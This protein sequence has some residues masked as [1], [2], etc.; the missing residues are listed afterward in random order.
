[1]VRA[2]VMTGVGRPLEVCEVELELPRAHE[3]MVRMAASGVCHSD[4]SMQDGT[5]MAP[6]PIVLGHEGAGVVEQVGPGVDAVE[7]GDHVVIAWV[8]QCGS[9]FFCRRGQRHLCELANVVLAS[10]GLLD[11]SPR[12]SSGGRPLY[13]MVAAGTFAELTVVPESGVVKVDDALDL[14]VAALLG[15]AVLTGVGA[16]TRTADISEGDSVAVVGCGGVGLNVVQGARLAGA[17]QVIAVDVSPAKLDLA[18]QFGATAAVDAGDG[19]PVSRVMELTAQRGTDVSFEVV[20][21]QR[22]IDQTIAM[23]RRGGQAVLVGIPKMDVMLQVPAFLGA[24]MAAKT[25]TGC[26]YGSA[27][28]RRDVPRIVEHYG[29]GDLKLDE[30]ISATIALDQVNDAFEAMKAGDVARSVI[31]YGAS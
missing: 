13:Q 24:V 26:W 4:L 11:G 6:T 3:V 18:R 29:N 5:M 30:L 16:A 21:L 19:N 15:C 25:I 23:T 17:G 7:P 1:M 2:A 22:S 8:P 14:E 20:G 28:V 12:F 10:G 27:D 31:R 9:C